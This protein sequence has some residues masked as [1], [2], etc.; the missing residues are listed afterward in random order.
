MAFDKTKL[1]ELNK[2]QKEKKKERKNRLILLKNAK[3]HACAEYSKSVENLKKEFKSKI[4]AATSVDQKKDLRGQLLDE[5][6]KAKI[7]RDYEIAKN[8]LTEKKQRLAK[9]RINKAI[10]FREYNHEL[11]NARTLYK[12]NLSKI[13][14]E[15]KNVLNS[16]KEKQ[17]LDKKSDNDVKSI[18]KEYLSKIKEFESQITQNKILLENTEIQLKLKRDMR[19][20]YELDRVFIIKRWWYGIGKEL[21]RMSWSSRKKTLFNFSYVIVIALFISLL[22][23]FLDFIITRI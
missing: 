23:L 6:F 12:S 19:Y 2:L 13:M 11:N 7:S 16:L 9:M 22:F 18:N 10:A 5:I 1:E 15:R 3:S 4:D 21:Q 17:K 14:T 8:L 20:E